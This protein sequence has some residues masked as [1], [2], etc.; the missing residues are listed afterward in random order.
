MSHIKTD[1]QMHI[2]TDISIRHITLGSPLLL[3]YQFKPSIMVQ[4]T[5]KGQA[6][7]RL[8]MVLRC[9]L[10]S[11]GPWKDPYNPAYSYQ[12]HTH[13]HK[14]GAW[15][16]TYM[17]FS[18]PSHPPSVCQWPVCVCVCVSHTDSS[19]TPSSPL[20]SRPPKPPIVSLL[21]S[22]VSA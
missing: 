2:H 19:L 4:R 10:V 13:T 14:K 9:E 6:W 22:I 5:V 11:V 16:L 12:T 3:G 7:P 21:P 15:S 18:L 8:P 20:L 17:T 1:Q